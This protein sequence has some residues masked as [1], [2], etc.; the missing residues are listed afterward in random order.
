MDVHV[1]GLRYFAAVARELS[2]T[3]AAEQLYV[4]QPALSK[5]IRALERQLHVTLSARSSRSVAAP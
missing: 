5:Q 2:F 4:S 1:R 3:R